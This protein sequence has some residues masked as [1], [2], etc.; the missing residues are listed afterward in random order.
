MD[1][2]LLVQKGPEEEQVQRTR[3]AREQLSINC[4]ID[5]KNAKEWYS[6]LSQLIIKP[7]QILQN[8]IQQAASKALFMLSFFSFET[9]FLQV[10]QHLA[11]GNVSEEDTLAQ[12]ALLQH[13]NLNSDQLAELFQ[14]IHSNAPTSYKKEKLQLAFAKTLRTTI[15]NWMNNYPLEFVTLCQGKRMQGNS[16]KTKFL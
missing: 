7:Q 15:W 16:L 12:L 9:I 6:K 14:R 3:T 2:V 8:T 5:S 1:F 11:S 13:I 10:T 4:T